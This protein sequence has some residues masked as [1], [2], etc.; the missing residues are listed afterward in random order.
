MHVPTSSILRA[1]LIKE[2]GGQTFLSESASGHWKYFS[3]SHQQFV[4]VP[5]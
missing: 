2:V 1:V 3:L 4:V 5:R